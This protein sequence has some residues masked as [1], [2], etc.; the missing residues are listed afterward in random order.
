MPRSVLVLWI[1]A[2]PVAYL[3]G[4]VGAAAV[5]W[6]G[7]P[8]RAERCS[9]LAVEGWRIYA[10]LGGLP[11]F[12]LAAELGLWLTVFQH[13]VPLP[14]TGLAEGA[15][16]V[17]LAVAP[18]PLIATACRGG[19]LTGRPA[20]VAGALAAAGLV[21]FVAGPALRDAAWRELR[22]AARTETA[23]LH[24]I[25]WLKGYRY[26][27][28]ERTGAALDGILAGPADVM[29]LAAECEGGAVP[30]DDELRSYLA[31]RLE[32]SLRAAPPDAPESPGTAAVPLIW[33]LTGDGLRSLAAYALA[34]PA[35]RDPSLAGAQ[36]PWTEVAAH[37]LTDAPPAV[38]AIIPPAIVAPA[39]REAVPADL[40]AALAPYVDAP[41]PTGTAALRVLVRDGSQEALR[42]IVARFAD[43]DD[44]VWNLLDDPRN[45]PQRT[46]GLVTLVEDPEPA[47]AAGAE[48]LLAYVRQYCVRARPVG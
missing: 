36:V 30:L 22:A 47:V 40:V 15:A 16:W 46:N 24:E 20:A 37:A 34:T 8:R 7:W 13:Q 18:L 27:D 2:N 11:G 21:L 33:C 38:A 29:A 39:G 9:E 45:C 14:F 28:A 6:L 10:L 5:I 35:F 4:L 17:L 12:L 41:D 1:I 19:H 43:P 23:A 48:A 31:T 42:P 25:A 44:A 3:F 32:A 26:V